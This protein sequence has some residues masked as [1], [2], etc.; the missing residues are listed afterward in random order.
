[1]IEP[2]FRILL[3]DAAAV[4][5]LVGDRLYFAVAPQNE[6]RPRIV[7][8]LVSARSGHTFAGRGGYVIGRMQ[9]DCLAPTYP[10]AKELAK[11]AQD[12]LDG[13]TGTTDGTA[14]DYIE[15]EESR[16]IPTAPPAGSAEP[17]TYGVTFDARF[18]HKE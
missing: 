1:M 8:A 5:P 10:Q 6:R 14:I 13:Y 12:A 9:V 17:T 16:D 7:L 18:M 4:A 3:K 11:A 15:T 2:A